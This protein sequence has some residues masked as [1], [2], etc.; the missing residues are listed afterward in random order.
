M[1]ALLISVK[2]ARRPK[3]YVEI[4]QRVWIWRERDQARIEELRRTF[5]DHKV[6]VYEYDEI[7]NGDQ[8]WCIGKHKWDLTRLEEG[9]RLDGTLS[10]L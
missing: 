10:P 7:L 8:Q 1:I 2:K 6:A 3:L 9:N 4:L 5:W